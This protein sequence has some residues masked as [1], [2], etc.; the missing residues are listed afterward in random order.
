[1]KL[2]VKHT[3]SGITLEQYGEL[4]FDESF[5]EYLCRGVNLLRNVKEKNL[6]GTR[7]TRITTVSPDRVIPAP[8]AKVIKM[9]RLE[10]DEELHYDTAAYKG[11]WKINVPG[12][13][14]SKFSAGGEFVFREVA[15]GVERELWGD[16]SVKVPLVG[17]KIEK[18]IMADVEKS[19]ETAAAQTSEYIRDNSAKFS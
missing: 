9:D 8:L 3:F 1:M 5:N 16:V 6:D 18:L 19:Y 7:L 11:T 4:Y 10:Y 15:G 17:S 14:G 12:P 13:I 2:H